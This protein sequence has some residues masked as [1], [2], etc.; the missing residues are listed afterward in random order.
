MQIAENL[1]AAFARFDEI[2]GALDFVVFEDARGDEAEALAA[3]ATAVPGWC[4]GAA[5]VL[6]PRQI[7]KRTF[8]GAWYDPDTKS[9]VRIGDSPAFAI[10]QAEEGGEFAYAF[11]WTPYGL[12]AQPCEVQEVFDAI[13]AFILPAGLDHTILDWSSP[14]LP[15]VSRYFEPGM[16]WWGVFLFTIHV[17]AL[18]RLTV[19]A[20]STT[21]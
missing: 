15:E 5:H 14:R 16:E 2:G 8:F 1:P 11:S 17:P 3:M 4:E 12:R 19:I 10:P 13:T 21:D 20:G 18:Q 9:L 6:S 7:D